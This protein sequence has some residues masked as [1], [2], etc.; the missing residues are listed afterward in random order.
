MSDIRGEVGGERG[1]AASLPII[2]PLAVHS[3]MGSY[4]TTREVV[5]R[6]FAVDRLVTLLPRFLERPAQ[7]LSEVC[8]SGRVSVNDQSARS[9]RAAGAERKCQTSVDTGEPLKQEGPEMKNDS[10]VEVP[11]ESKRPREA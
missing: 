7:E 10:I 9:T 8:G 1:P 4:P 2:G 11:A 6:R 3:A 5:G